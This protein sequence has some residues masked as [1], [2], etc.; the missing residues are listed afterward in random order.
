M[1]NTYREDDLEGCLSRWSRWATGDALGRAGL[2]P[3]HPPVDALAA[4]VANHRAIE[5]LQARRWWAVASARDAGY[6]WEQIGEAVGESA[7]GARRRY[8]DELAGSS[9]PAAL[10][11]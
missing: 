4:L 10:A 2:T 8:G 6:T 9:S 11:S 3:D 7:D 1:S 5:L